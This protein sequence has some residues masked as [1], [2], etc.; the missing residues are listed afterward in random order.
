MIVGGVF[1][2][3]ITFPNVSMAF[4]IVFI[5]IMGLYSHSHGICFKVFIAISREEFLSVSE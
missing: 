2:V 5:L 3:F 1:N 4:P